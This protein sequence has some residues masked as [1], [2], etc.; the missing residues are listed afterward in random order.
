MPDLR[1]PLAPL[2]QRAE[3]VLAVAFLAVAAAEELARS[4][5][6]SP[7][8][9]VAG[10]LA[11]ASPILLRRNHP[12]AGAYTASAVIVALSQSDGFSPPV[13]TYLLPPL[14]AYS[15]GAHAP[16]LKGL[17]AVA[18][19]AIAIQIH[20]GFAEAPNLEIVVT[21]VPLW[22]GGLEVGRRRRLVQELTQRTRELAAEEEAFVQLSVRRERARIAR[23]LHDIVSHHL[24]VMVIQAGAG[25]LAEPWQAGVA[26]ERFATIRDAGVQAL[27]ETERLVTML[28]ADNTG[29][30][31]LAQLLSRARAG[32][33]R[34]V[35]E[36]PDL[37]LPPQIE[38]IAYRVVQEALTNAM[39]HAPDATIDLQVGLDGD[40]LAITVRNETVAKTSAIAFTGSGL[41]LTGMRERLG[42]LGGS[43][44]AGPDTH[45]GFC[46]DARLPV[47][48]AS[49]SVASHA[50]RPGE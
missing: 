10:G 45:G 48:V 21:T 5:S 13:V 47:A 43:L 27:T 6:E 2:G 20:M 35:V 33:A 32:G 39:K 28:Q 1:S 42:A 18:A 7:L 30:P 19:M 50:P 26:G 11:C 37:G 8:W 36:P 23:D 14:L 41:G 24:A 25:R 31:R 9:A 44:A 34:V 16:P 17:L 49:A 12:V 4:G 46:L 40:E 22:W 15:C 29:A 3:L 38:A